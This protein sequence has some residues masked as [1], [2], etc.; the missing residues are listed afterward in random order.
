MSSQ[1]ERKNLLDKGDF[2][3]KVATKAAELFICSNFLWNV[4]VSSNEMRY[5]GKDKITKGAFW[6]S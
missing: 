3:C 1:A 4:N 2:C 6:F 5:L